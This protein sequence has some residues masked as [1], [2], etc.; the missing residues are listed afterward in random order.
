M[1]VGQILYLLEREYGTHPRR[2]HRDAVSELILTILSQ[3]TSD[4]NSKRAFDKLVADF[5]T[6]QAVA[7]ARVED[8][9]AS[10]RSGGL[11]QVKAGRIK[12]ILRQIPEREGRLDLEFLGQLPT[13]EAKAWLKQLPG[14]GPKT[15]GCVLLFSLGRPVLPVD[16]HVYRV[17]QRLGLIG[18]KVS[19]PKAH[20]VLEN[21]VPPQDI[22]RFHLLTIEHG[23]RIC[24]AQKPLC[25]RCV[26]VE[27]CPS[28]QDREALSGQL[29]AL[30]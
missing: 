19:P 1:T 20:D 2:H 26:L 10:I 27:A 5:G 12:R 8:I 28:R 17:A 14:V 25:H 30:V 21:L 22:Y 29:V 9:Q 3:N 11:A 18:S 24:R 15:A 4:V 7:E 13:Q 6:W 23:R 16:T